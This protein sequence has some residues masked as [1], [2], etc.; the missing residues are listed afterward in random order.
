MLF[1]SWKKRKWLL[2]P[3]EGARLSLVT[4]VANVDLW[5]QLANDMFQEQVLVLVRLLGPIWNL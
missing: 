3:K 2:Q 5:A 4:L 1:P